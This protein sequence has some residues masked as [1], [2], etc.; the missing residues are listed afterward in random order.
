MRADG[1]GWVTVREEHLCEEAKR[2]GKRDYAVCTWGPFEVDTGRTRPGGLCKN[3][4]GP[5][6][7]EEWRQR[8]Y[9]A[10]DRKVAA[11]KK[12]A[13]EKKAGKKGEK[14]SKK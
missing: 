2:Y 11:E 13:E 3:C 6:D 8:E 10:A 5:A 14:S 7:E 1:L 4:G 9:D 12:A